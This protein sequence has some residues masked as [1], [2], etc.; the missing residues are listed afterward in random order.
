MVRKMRGPQE[1]YAVVKLEV[2]VTVEL[3]NEN[4]YNGQMCEDPAIEA[5]MEAVDRGPVDIYLWGQ[6]KDP[7][8]VYA[9]VYEV[10]AEIEEDG[11]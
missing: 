2:T 4:K 6:D 10:D 8:R 11:R 9:E 1:P 3:P 7:A 5:A